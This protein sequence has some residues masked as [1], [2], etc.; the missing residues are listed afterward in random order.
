MN[1][2]N[3]MQIAPVIPVIVIDDIVDA[4]P[5]CQA[6]VNGGLR[7]LEITLRSGCALEA[8]TLVKEQ[9]KGA[10][11][12]AGTVI[13]AVNVIDA[14][15]AGAE[16]LVSPGATPSLI[17]AAATKGIP[18]LPGVS[19]ASEAMVLYDQGFECMKFFPAQAA[20]GI[21]ML[22]S[23]LGPLPHL[24]FCPTGGINLQNAC[25]YLK[26]SNVLCVGGS[27]MITPEDVKAKAWSEIERKARLAASVA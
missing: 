14:V 20:G 6:L 2:K 8:I 17:E 9:V 12:G 25:A 15:S 7:V 1:I 27:W 10:V 13:T 11:V 19:T 23:F 5:L 21:P 26:L 18:L 24:V 4:V 16:F 22:Q 3:I